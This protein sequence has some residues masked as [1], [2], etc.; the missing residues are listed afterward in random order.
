M[1]RE[2]D[3][4]NVAVWT[5]TAYYRVYKKNWTDLKLPQFRKTAI[6][7]YFFMYIAALGTYKVE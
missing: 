7:I 3:V 6:S 1:S 2:S 4:N 5:T